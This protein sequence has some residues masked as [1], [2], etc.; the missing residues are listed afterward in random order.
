MISIE[1]QPVGDQILQVR[2]GTSISPEINEQ[3]RTF[4]IT[5]EHLNLGEIVEWVPSY[6][7][8]SIYYD[9]FKSTYENVQQKVHQ[10]IYKMRRVE[11]PPRN[12]IT[13]PVCYDEEFGPDLLDVA[14]YNKLSV[15]EVIKL[16]CKEKYLVYM[17]GFTPGF[18]YLGGLNPA[19]AT[20]R[21]E[22]PRQL[23]EKG[24]VG[25]AG[26]QTGVYSLSSPGGWRIIGRTPVPLFNDKCSPPSLLNAGDFLRFES[27]TKQQ[28]RQ[29]EEQVKLN[30]YT[31]S[32][33]HEESD[34]NETNNRLE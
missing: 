21:L 9:P 32:I 4:C 29:I 11:L 10:V 33:H 22:V 23:V 28:Y 2:F 18:P 5:L 24:S 15:E 1:T 20:P 12:I 30:K 34:G 13:L 31:V 8:V 26:S 19:I 25:I 14:K 6:T 17:I 3:I 27:I 16:H 7:T